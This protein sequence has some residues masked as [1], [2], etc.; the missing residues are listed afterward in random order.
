MQIL[1]ACLVFSIYSHHQYFETNSSY[2][3]FLSFF[4]VIQYIHC[5]CWYHNHCYPT[6]N[7]IQFIFTVL[8]L[9]TGQ[10]GPFQNIW[11]FIVFAI[12]HYIPKYFYYKPICFWNISIAF[13]LTSIG[14]C[15]KAIIS[16]FNIKWKVY[17]SP[18][19]Q[20][21]L[22]LCLWTWMYHYISTFFHCYEVSLHVT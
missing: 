1:D 7:P 12:R 3:T 18:F 17:L 15:N 13:S 8:T 14:F 6:Q 5:Q 9:L 21:I 2:I 20:K 22:K 10:E 4:Y 11:I 16:G 19:V